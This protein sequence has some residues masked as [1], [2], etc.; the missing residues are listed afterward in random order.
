MKEETLNIEQN[1]DGWEIRILP[2]AKIDMM[3]LRIPAERFEGY[4][5]GDRFAV[6]AAKL[7]KALNVCGDAVD[8]TVEDRITMRGDGVRMVAPRIESE[9]GVAWPVLDGM[10]T[11]VVMASDEL[12]RMSDA[13][14]DSALSVLVKVSGDGVVM[15]SAD[16][17]GVSSAQ[18]ELP[19]EKC[20]MCEG[21]SEGLYN[22]MP[23]RGFLKGLPRGVDID[24]RLAS[25][26][27]M[28]I[29]FETESG[30]SGEYMLAPWIEE[31]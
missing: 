12:R 28:S 15:T 31:E 7:S 6:D 22:W 3:R 17:T 21:E 25:R 19:A 9:E 10:D 26:Y 27:P 5:P 4:V 8:I 11:E 14:P 16:D 24:I 29:K 2:P 23:L 20:V 1:D 13:A 30:L 18:I